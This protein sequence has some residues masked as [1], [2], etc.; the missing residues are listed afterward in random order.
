MT[1]TPSA[2]DA[3]PRS[4]TRS[5]SEHPGDWG[6]ALALALEYLAVQVAYRER[7]PEPGILVGRDVLIRF[8]ASGEGV[9]IVAELAHGS[10]P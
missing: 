2:E 9:V 1:T 7:I 5:S 6:R 4:V 3:R 8:E 10:T